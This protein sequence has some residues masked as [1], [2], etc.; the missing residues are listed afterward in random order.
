MDNQRSYLTIISRS[1]NGHRGMYEDFI[2]SIYRTKISRKGISI[3][4]KKDVFY[5]MIEESFLNYFISCIF[6]SILLRKTSGLLFNP[7]AALRKK[8][9]KAFLKRF[10]LKILKINPF[11]KTFTILPH[12]IDSD[13]RDISDASI[14]DFQLWDLSE[15]QV[16]NFK[17]YKN[18]IGNPFNIKMQSKL[19]AFAKG[20]KIILSLGAQ[21]KNKGIDDLV[22]ASTFLSSEDFCFVCAGKQDDYSKALLKK[23]PSDRLICFNRFMNDIELFELYAA[24]DFVWCFYSFEYDQASGIFGRASQLG[25]RSILRKN[26]LI[27]K[28]AVNEKFNHIAIDNIFDLK[29]LS[30]DHKVKNKIKNRDS[31]KLSTASLKSL[32]SSFSIY[33]IPKDNDF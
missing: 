6:R 27:H 8:S 20:R 25:V 18:E 32:N 5:I 26:S 21:T 15:E 24:S 1:R 4:S 31:H 23:L 19:R 28:L 29:R 7:L 12:Y 9:L 3:F 11:V 16:Q 10:A 30:L 14:Y 22:N 13:F 33:S 2:S 17:D